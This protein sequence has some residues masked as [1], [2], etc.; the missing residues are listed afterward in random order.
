VRC[1]KKTSS[2]EKGEGECVYG[3][4][5]LDAK[6]YV[7]SKHVSPPPFACKPAAN[8]CAR[9]SALRSICKKDHVKEQ[10]MYKIKYFAYLCVTRKSVLK[11]MFL[12][13]EIQ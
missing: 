10:R 12:F 5:A 7:V 9:M 2:C 13:L 6:D 11:F 1:R 8:G 4:R 3:F